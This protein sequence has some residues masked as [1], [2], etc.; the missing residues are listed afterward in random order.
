[1]PSIASARR[2]AAI[3]IACGLPAVASAQDID[4]VNAML[5]DGTGRIRV[6]GIESRTGTIRVGLEAD[7]VVVEGYGL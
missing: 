4:L 1:M 5:V 2:C 7:L 6:L 3:L